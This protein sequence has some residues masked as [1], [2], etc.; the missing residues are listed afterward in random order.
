MKNWISG[1][2]S[3]VAIIIS[4]IALAKVAPT[5]GI[6][7]DYIGSIVGILSFLVTLLIGYQIYTIINVKEELKEVQKV[8]GEIETKLQLKAEELYKEYKDELANAAPLIM[9]IA[10]T[11]RDIVE[12]EV[13]KAYRVS[14]SG[15]LAKE[16]SGR[17]ILVMLM[18][19]SK[20]KKDERKNAI[21]ELSRNIERE[22]VVEFYADYVKREKRNREVEL[23]L[24]ELI[25]SFTNKK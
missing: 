17:T 22:D 21:E 6:N 20:L 25:E 19:L 13:F 15:Q 11:D 16:L 7:F 10:S 1:A 3:I 12:S 9:A 18:E 4:V 24:L 23:F 5:Q 8:R 14:K 2:L